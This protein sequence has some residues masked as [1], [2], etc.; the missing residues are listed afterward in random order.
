[1]REQASMPH[2][3]LD[4]DGHRVRRK[5]PRLGNI[6]MLRPHRAPLIGNGLSQATW[7]VDQLRAAKASDVVSSPGRQRQQAL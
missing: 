6:Y 1:M 4:V 5:A 2:K 7:S 3:L